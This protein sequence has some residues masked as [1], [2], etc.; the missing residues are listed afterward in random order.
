[1]KKNKELLKEME[2]LRTEW[3]TDSRKYRSKYNDMYLND[4]TIMLDTYKTTMDNIGT[5]EEA[6]VRLRDE[7]E[8]AL[9]LLHSEHLKIT[10]EQLKTIGNGEK[11][12]N[13]L[14]ATLMAQSIK[15]Y[16][17]NKGIAALLDLAETD[18][19]KFYKSMENFSTDKSFVH[20]F[21]CA[22]DFPDTVDK[23][24]KSIEDIKQEV[25]S[26]F[27]FTSTGL[28]GGAGGSA[29][30]TTEKSTSTGMSKWYWIVGIVIVVA[31]VVCA[32]GYF[33]MGAKQ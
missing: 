16:T 33:L 25:G 3:K 4:R 15:G 23:I 13:D 14:G 19:K 2:E 32:I 5:V 27:S 17:T 12:V 28:S 11:M 22:G 9:K 18:Q 7:H 29:T 8:E 31:L 10:E 20:G 1:M 30:T 6:A 26:K 21:A 24:R